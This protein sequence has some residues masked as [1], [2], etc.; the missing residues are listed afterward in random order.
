ME[1]SSPGRLWH[2][3]DRRRHGACTPRPEWGEITHGW[4]CWESGAAMG[5]M[6]CG[7]VMEMVVLGCERPV[8]VAVMVP[9][10]L[11]AQSLW[12]FVLVGSGR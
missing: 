10:S 9:Q 4:E 11:W 12:A 3:R 8:V 5:G 7:L 2:P 6:G 1:A